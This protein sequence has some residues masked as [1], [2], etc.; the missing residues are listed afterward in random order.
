MGISISN[1]ALLI[2]A[3]SRGVKFD[4]T[5]TLG[6]QTFWPDK[7]QFNALL[8]SFNWADT[9]EAVFEKV[10]NKGSLFFKYLGADIVTEIDASNYEGARVVHDMNLPIPN[11]LENRFDCIFDG[12]TL[13]HIFNFPQVVE[14]IF[15]MLKKDGTFISSTVANNLLGHGFYQFSP[16]LFF[17]V[18]S[19]DNGWKTDAVL[20][21]EHQMVPPRFWKVQDPKTVGARLELQNNNQLYLMIITKK[22]RDEW[23]FV[24]PQQSDYSA[25]WSLKNNI[26]TRIDPSFFVR[27]HNRFKKI[28]K[29]KRK[30]IEMPNTLT[31]KAKNLNQYGITKVN[32]NKI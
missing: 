3:K 22:I 27:I 26:K 29:I 15:R 1:A 4:C 30:I 18:F 10:G 7:K 31:K 19:D 20:L 13:E 24:I 17:R 9:A 21:C 32:V 25:A 8:K 11:S 2:A 6:V 5:A 12:G 28:F 16:E 14:N 23:K